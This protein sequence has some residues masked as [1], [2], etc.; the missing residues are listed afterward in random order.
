MNLFENTTSLL[1]LHNYYLIVLFQCAIAVNMDLVVFT[2]VE[3]V[4]EVLLTY[5]QV[6]AHRDVRMDTKALSAKIVSDILYCQIKLERFI[7]TVCPF[8]VS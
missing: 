1:I 6:R 3:A 5:K 7:F 8:Y 2:S 4:S